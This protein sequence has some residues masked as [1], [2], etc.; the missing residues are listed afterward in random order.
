MLSIV[1]FNK[2][3]SRF[4][5]KLFKGLSFC[6]NRSDIHVFFVDDGS[7][8]ESQKKAKM[9]GHTLKQFHYIQLTPLG[10]KRLI[11]AFG[12]LEGIEY[13]LKYYEE[14]LQDYILFLDSDDWL[15]DNFIDEI[16]KYLS[17]MNYE[18]IFNKTLN[19][20]EKDNDISTKTY[21]VA[22]KVGHFRE[23]NLAHY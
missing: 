10:N 20:I 12:Q 9:L 8:D 14:Y 1:I 11:P 5:D 3:Y 19:I 21:L 15:P 16:D 17:S 22:R 23:P 7:S 2:N 18:V 4:F 13:I 6:K